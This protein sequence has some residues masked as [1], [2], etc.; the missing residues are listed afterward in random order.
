M[1]TKEKKVIREVCEQCGKTK[2]LH[3]LSG[4][5]PL[6]GCGC[7]CNLMG[8]SSYVGCVAWTLDPE[9]PDY[10]EKPQLRFV[11]GEDLAWNNWA[12]A[13]KERTELLQT[14]PEYA[15]EL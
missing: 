9:N 6:F 12:L 3:G 8:W 7:G 10:D 14:Y 15:A 11:T 13:R 1:D 2:F 5:R 4:N